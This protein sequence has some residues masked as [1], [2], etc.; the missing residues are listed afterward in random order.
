MEIIIAAQR[1]GRKKTCSNN[2]CTKLSEKVIFSLS[3]FFFCQ[4]GGIRTRKNIACAAKANWTTT[5]CSE[6][7]VFLMYLHSPVHFLPLH[8]IQ[9]AFWVDF[10]VVGQ[11]FCFRS[12]GGQPPSKMHMNWAKVKSEEERTRIPINLPQRF[13]RLVVCDRR[14]WPVHEPMH[15]RSARAPIRLLCAMWNPTIP[16]ASPLLFRIPVRARRE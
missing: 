11:S 7:H 10:F 4:C 2:N 3:P 8:S 5:K 16:A 1:V 14:W 9:L 6:L 13:Y 15:A 12:G